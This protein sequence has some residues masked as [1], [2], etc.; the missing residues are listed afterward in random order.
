LISSSSPIWPFSSGCVSPSSSAPEK[1]INKRQ[2][3]WVTYHHC[4]D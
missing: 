1:T 3:N 2:Q 4:T